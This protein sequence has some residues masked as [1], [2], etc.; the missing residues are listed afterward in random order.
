MILTN[1]TRRRPPA[2]SIPGAPWTPGTPPSAEARRQGLHRARA[3]RPHLVARG[4]AVPR[5]SAWR[6]PASTRTPRRCPRRRGHRQQGRIAGTASCISAIVPSVRRTWVVSGGN[7]RATTTW[8]PRIPGERPGV[9]LHVDHHESWRTTAARESLPP[10]T[11]SRVCGGRRHCGRAPSRRGSHRQG[12]AS[13]GNRGA[14][15]P[16]RHDAAGATRLQRRQRVGMRDRV[17]D[18][19]ARHAEPLRERP[20]HHDPPSAMAI[21]PHWQARDPRRTRNRPRRRGPRASGAAA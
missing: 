9:A 4:G 3:A 20:R 15:H 8:C 5:L 12:R 17:A 21:G 18:P 7:G 6:R 10:R 16:T 13:R 19:Q 11:S 1:P 2:G 14:A